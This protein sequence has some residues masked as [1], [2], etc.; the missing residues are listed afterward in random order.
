MERGSN[1]GEKR[2]PNIC[3]HTNALKV[4]KKSFKPPDPNFLESVT[5]ITINYFFLGF[6]IINIK[7]Y[8]KED[9]V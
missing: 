4:K 5:G 2:I 1:P 6:R 8:K 9:A 7:K 3:S